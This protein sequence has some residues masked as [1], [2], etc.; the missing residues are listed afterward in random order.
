MHDLV[1]EEGRFG[2]V[3]GIEEV[4][5]VEVGVGGEVER[6]EVCDGTV[7]EGAPGEGGIGEE[8]GGEEERDDGE[9]EGG[10]GEMHCNVL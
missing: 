3:L 4:S 7:A 8:D 5:G 6:G 1:G 10:G 2:Y 9:G